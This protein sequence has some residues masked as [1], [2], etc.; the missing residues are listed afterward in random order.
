MIA[1]FSE[2]VIFTLKQIISMSI[3]VILTQSID[4]SDTTKLLN[5]SDSQ[6]LL[7]SSSFLLKSLPNISIF[8]AVLA[9]FSIIIIE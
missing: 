1:I 3:S 8:K 7:Y 2:S 6:G 4:K 9:I 5:L